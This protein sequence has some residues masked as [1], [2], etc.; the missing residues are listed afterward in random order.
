M[1]DAAAAVATSLADRYRLERELGRGGMATVYLAHDLRHDRK[2]AIK[3]LHPELAVVLGADRF[4]NEIRVTANLQHP[5]ILALYDSGTTSGY[6]YYVMPYVDGESLRQRLTRERQLPIP[7]ALRLAR[8]VAEALDYAHRHGVI[9]R[10]IKPENILLQEGR[11]LVAD[12][13]IALAVRNAGGERITQTGLSLGTP[14]YMSPE[15]ATAER[16]LDA[17]SDIYSLGCVLYEMLAGETPHTGP[18]TQSIIAKIVTD[19][20]RPI[21]QL[22]ETVSTQVEAAL[23]TALAKLPADRFRTASEMAAALAQAGPGTVTAGVTGAGRAPRG[24]FW[25]LAIAAGL[26]AVAVGVG[27][28]LGRRPATPAGTLPSQLSITASD[29]TATALV[30]DGSAIVYV[31]RAAGSGW[32][33]MRRLD[34]LE[35]VTLPGSPFLY[36]PAVSPDGRWLAGLNLAGD[37]VLLPLGGPGTPRQVGAGGR[38]FL[39]WHPDGSLW[40]SRSPYQNLE[41]LVLDRDSLEVRIAQLP[42]RVWLQQILDDGRTGLVVESQPGSASGPC[43][44][45]NL[46]SGVLTPLIESPIIGARYTAGF[47]VFVRPDASLH[48]APFDPRTLKVHGPAVAIVPGVVINGPGDPMFSVARNGTLVYAPNEPQSLVLV[49]RSGSARLATDARRSFHAPDFSPD[50]RRLAVDVITGDSRDVWVLDLQQSTLARTTF[51]GDGHDPVWMPDGRRITYTSHHSGE[52]GIYRVPPGGTA[53][54]ESLLASSSLNYAGH[55][56]PDGSG[57][58]VVATDLQAGSSQDIGLV[59]KGGLIE[60]LVATPF[61]EAYPDISPDGRWL[62]FVSDRSGESRVYV[63]ALSGE[64]EQIQVSQ[65]GGGEPV[66][67]PNGREIFY[68]TIAGQPNELMVARV[69]AT[70]EF[71]VLSRHSLFP[72]GDYSPSTPH[73]GYDVSPDGTRFA[74]VRR[75][76]ASR[77]VVI[78]NLPELIR[79]LQGTTAER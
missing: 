50:G 53:P 51:T 76:A 3:V 28:M 4:L 56:L 33:A 44:A 30:P 13:G 52:F 75:T 14:Q 46:E 49:D 39:A 6:L 69:E 27:W 19:R 59:R 16:E 32:L 21:T 79:R 1:S 20:P 62:V 43:F 31:S 7:D 17:R 68:R 71:R 57:Q 2:V 25:T 48:A 55:W 23:H 8:E 35:A 47:L 67:G 11:A 65:A 54:P 40:L 9:H 22:R 37:P 61:Q 15:Q 38:A 29:I 58:L 73:A 77:L 34:Q 72:V 24:R 74:M 70:P 42:R 12:F 18:T 63:R 66:W 60:P 64:G 26:L 36:N 10:D 5:H 78:Q 45:I 41:R